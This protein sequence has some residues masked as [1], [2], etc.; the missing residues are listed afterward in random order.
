MRTLA[1][2]AFASAFVA[3][4]TVAPLKV[5]G[6]APRSAM[7]DAET[8]PKTRRK[9]SMQDWDVMYGEL[10]SYRSTWGTADAPLGDELG[11]WCE[12][13]R[14]LKKS[15]KL[16]AERADK[17]DLLKFAWTNPSQLTPEELEARWQENVEA[18]VA[19]V[20]AHGDAQVPK[21][22]R[23]NPVLG[24]WVAALRRRGR[25][26]LPADRRR[27]LDEAGFEWISSRA[28]GSAF[29][30]GF[31]NYRDWRAAAAAGATPPEDLAVW[32]AATKAAAAKGKLSAER[33]DYLGSVAF[34]ETGGKVD[35]A[36]FLD[37][38]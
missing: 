6:F 33:L 3:K 24:G 4:P 17:L 2:V 30:K 38:A 14:R 11:R 9:S 35:D 32:V 18:L 15:G 5:L 28:C 36:A 25:D 16:A 23:E 29:M 1:V 27:D 20:A 13:Q 37:D 26:V 31:R 8:K 12:A 21:K 7:K 22:W 19:Y 34:F 10:S